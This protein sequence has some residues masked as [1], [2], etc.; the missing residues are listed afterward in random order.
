MSLKDQVK[1]YVEELEPKLATMTQDNIKF[2]VLGDSD[3]DSCLFNSLLATVWGSPSTVVNWPLMAV[4][5]CQG[6]NGM[7]YRSPRRRACNNEGFGG[8]YFSRDMATGVIAA[9]TLT[10]FPARWWDEWLAYID[11]SRPCSIKKPKWLGGGCL[12]RSPVYYY[13]PDDRSAISPNCWAMM[14]RVAEARS[15]YQQGQMKVWAGSDGDA[16]LVEA[17]NCET[18]Y[19]LHLKAVDAFIKLLINQSREYSQ[20]VGQIAWSRVPDNMFYEF[21]ATRTINDNF[22]SRYLDLAPPVGYR[23]QH[24]WVWEKSSVAES[25]PYTCGWDFVFLGR[26]I[27]KF[28]KGVDHLF[29]QSGIY[30]RFPVID[31]HNDQIGHRA[32]VFIPTIDVYGSLLSDERICP[33]FG[34]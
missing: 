2:A 9:A 11:R 15:W 4:L 16:S 1:K 18:G 7:F 29:S 3:G 33:I 22:I 19:Q 8:T 28:C 23:F 21:L 12:V 30:H 34:F 14:G 6:T 5:M 13:A 32:T 24:H 17:E 27:L 20:K 10:G 25:M 31:P 26:L